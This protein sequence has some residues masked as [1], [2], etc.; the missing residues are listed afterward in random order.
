MAGS[1]G[2][3]AGVLGKRFEPFAVRQMCCL[4]RMCQQQAG[5]P[6]LLPLVAAGQGRLLLHPPLP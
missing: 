5:G 3:G 1:G 4:A 6:A 2:Q